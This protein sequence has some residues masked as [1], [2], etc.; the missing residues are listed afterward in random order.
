VEKRI[1]GFVTLAERIPLLDL[2]KVF[3]SIENINMSLSESRFFGLGTVKKTQLF[4]RITSTY[5]KVHD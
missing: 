5:K 4:E 3:A 2:P 1:P